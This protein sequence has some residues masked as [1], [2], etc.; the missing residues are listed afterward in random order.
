MRE[1]KV[2]RALRARA[3]RDDGRRV[4]CARATC[5]VRSNG[6]LL[7]TDVVED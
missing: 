5:H 7:R 6:V 4:V 3:R 1:G 2:E